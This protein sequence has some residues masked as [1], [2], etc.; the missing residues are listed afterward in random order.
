MTIQEI[1]NDLIDEFSMF[2]DWMERY[3][4]MIELGK[5]LP[6]IDEE[7]KTEDKL[8]KG[9]QSRVWLNAEVKDDKVVF[10]ADSDAIIT[11]GII[12]ILI[13][14]FSNQKPEDIIE[15]DTQFIDEIGLK[16]HLSPTRANGLVSM[17]KQLKLYAVAYQAQLKN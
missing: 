15:A 17:V 13:R 4:Y 3:E 16:E 12:A 9:C 2:D 11:K 7:L 8:I 6:L 14:A 10:T 5:S 1:Q